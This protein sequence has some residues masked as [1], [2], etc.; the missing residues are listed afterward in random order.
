[1][2]TKALSVNNKPM[3]TCDNWSQWSLNS[4]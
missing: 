4:R 2:F 3:P 1:M